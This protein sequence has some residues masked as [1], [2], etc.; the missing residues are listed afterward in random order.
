MKKLL[1]VQACPDDSCFWWQTAVQLN[2]FRKYGYSKDYHALIF[3]PGDRLHHGFSGKWKYLERKFPEAHFH[4]IKDEDGIMEVAKMVDY[5]PLLRPYCL[6][7]FLERNPEFTDAAIFYCDSDI[8]FTKKPEIEKLVDDDIN[9]LSYTGTK[10]TEYNYMCHEHFTSKEQNIRDDMKEQYEKEDILSKMTTWFGVKKQFFVYN[11]NS[12]GGAQYLLKNMT[13]E[14]FKK[15]YDGCI[16]IRTLLSMANQ[17]L[18][19]GE[20][21]EERENNGWQS[22]CAD[23]WSIQLSLWGDGRKTRCP[24]EMNFCWATDKIEKWNKCTIY[25]DAGGTATPIKDENGK[26]HKLFHKKG[27]RINGKDSYMH[28][29]DHEELRNPFMD[30]LSFVSKD[31]CSFN[32]V[33]E[34]LETKKYLL[35]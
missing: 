27:E 34:L 4:Y 25:H 5:I 9:Y 35:T 21:K 33:K 2:N 17:Q 16:V 20:T 32:Y 31:Y 15:V 7:K 10:E 8:L 29:W 30:D 28:S 14:F 23:M 22:W 3:L 26:E 11:K 19:K 24:D 18:M 12:I 1:F 6:Q 13:P